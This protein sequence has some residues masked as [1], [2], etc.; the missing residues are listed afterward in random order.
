[1][2]VHKRLYFKL[3]T[4][5]EEGEVYYAILSINI[6]WINKYGAPDIFKIL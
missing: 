2:M 3:S 6:Y 1:M 5:F 4:V